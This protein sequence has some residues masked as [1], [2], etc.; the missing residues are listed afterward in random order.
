MFLSFESIL[1]P[2]SASTSVVTE[3]GLFFF[4]VEEQNRGSSKISNG[5]MLPGKL[6]NAVKEPENSNAANT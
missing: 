6:T 4:F 2:V 1:G 5:L 3:T